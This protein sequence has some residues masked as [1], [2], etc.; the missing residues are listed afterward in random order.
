MTKIKHGDRIKLVDWQIATAS[1]ATLTGFY[2]GADS[3]MKGTIADIERSRAKG[4]PEVFATFAGSALSAD[5]S[6]WKRDKD[7]N[8]AAIVVA[9]GEIVEVEGNHYKIQVVTGNTASPR[10]SDPIH[11]SPIV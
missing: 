11:F 6:F 9:H 3:T 2:T 10:N 5:K 7:R 8:A 4:H 1:V